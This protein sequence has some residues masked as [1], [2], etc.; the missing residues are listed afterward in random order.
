M[1]VRDCIS[2]LEP[3]KITIVVIGA[4]SGGRPDLS[5]CHRPRTWAAAML[6]NEELK[7]RI[8]RNMPQLVLVVMRLKKR[9]QV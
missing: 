4:Y 6:I 8:E 7:L 5:W 2:F 9:Y 1:Y 3:I